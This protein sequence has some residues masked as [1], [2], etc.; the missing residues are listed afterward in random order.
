MRECATLVH[1]DRGPLVRGMKRVR[2][3][4]TKFAHADWLHYVIGRLKIQDLLDVAHKDDREFFVVEIATDVQEEVFAGHV[5]HDLVTQNEIDG[6]SRKDGGSVSSLG[7]FDPSRE[8]DFRERVLKNGSRAW[9]VIDYEDRRLTVSVF[10][11][12]GVSKNRYS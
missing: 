5:E 6:L 4:P 10:I 2:K 12:D 8:A 1:R 7:G 11:D 3:F 9:N